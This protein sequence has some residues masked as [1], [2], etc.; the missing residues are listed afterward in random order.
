[1]SDPLIDPECR[2]GEHSRCEGGPYGPCQCACHLSKPPP[3]RARAGGGPPG[4]DL[5]YDGDLQFVKMKIGIGVLRH[6][7]TRDDD[8]N[9][10]RLELRGP[11]RDGY[12]EA[13]VTTD[14]SN[15]LLAGR[16]RAD[17]GPDS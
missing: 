17:D 7:L 15:S 9:R 11:D 5:Q 6:F 1:M 10:L 13:V 12:F 8:G 16:A 3:P 4:P 2:T 14:Y